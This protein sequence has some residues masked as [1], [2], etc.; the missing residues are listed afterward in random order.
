MRQSNFKG[1]A[2]VSVCVVAHNEAPRI[3]RCLESIVNQTEAGPFEILVIDNASSDDT[4]AVAVDFLAAASKRSEGAWGWRVLKHEL[5][6][7]GR[8]R[9]AAV[10]AA[11][12][13]FIA[14]TDADCVVPENWLKSMLAGLS[15]SRANCPDVAGVGSG[16]RP[17]AKSRFHRSQ[18][19]AFTSFIG[20]FGSEQFRLGGPARV[21]RHLPTCSVLYDR[22]LILKVGGFSER[23][24]RVCEDLDLSY[25]LGGAN[26]KL[27]KIAGAE[28][29]H[30]HQESYRAW[31]Q[32]IFSYGFGQIDIMR[33]VP[34]HRS[35]KFFLPPALILAFPALGLFGLKVFLIGLGLYAVG[36]VLAAMGLALGS[37]SVTLVPD[38]FAFLA[39][40]H[41]SYGLGMLGGLI[42]LPLNRVPNA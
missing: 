25:R 20:N 34:A 9:Q 6:H 41:F 19:I 14:F 30:H 32:K 2:K 3:S 36:L 5:N 27:L 39:V 31:A 7:L 24:A 37:G 16:N 35:L 15:D 13:P 22:A 42:E 17:P 10:K 12:T 28:V 38:L 26:L 11:A 33:R 8:G 21:V 40:T 4:F 18:L 23:Q 1:S 29:T